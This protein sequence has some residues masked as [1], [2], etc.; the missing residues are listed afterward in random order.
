MEDGTS[1]GVM[2]SKPTKAQHLQLLNHTSDKRS[3]GCVL[4]PLPHCYFVVTQANEVD[5]PLRRFR[6]GWTSLFLVLVPRTAYTRITYRSTAPH[7]TIT[8]TSS[9][10]EVPNSMHAVCSS[11]KIYWL[12]T[13]LFLPLYTSARANLMPWHSIWKAAC[14]G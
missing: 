11:K 6:A 14:Q 12:L 8:R 13:V 4:N 3:R 1:R 2:C 7:V 9:A 10:K 5:C